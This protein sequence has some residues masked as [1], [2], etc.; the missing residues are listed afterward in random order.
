MQLFLI[1]SFHL[2]VE[3]FNNK[4]QIYEEILIICH[5]INIIIIL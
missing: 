3:I 1:N 4:F 5:E 2:W